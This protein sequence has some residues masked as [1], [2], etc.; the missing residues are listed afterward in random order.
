MEEGLAKEQKNEAS[1]CHAEYEARE[2]RTLPLGVEAGFPP[3]RVLG[4][5]DSKVP[6][7]V[8]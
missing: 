5:L 2:K 8:V 7:L 3:T 6:K 4:R 1:H